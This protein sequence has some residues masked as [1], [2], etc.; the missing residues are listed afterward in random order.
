MDP[1]T[2]QS[3]KRSVPL[4]AKVGWGIAWTAML[5][6]AAMIMRNCATSVIYGLKTDQQAVDSSHQEGL[7]DGGS[8]KEQNLQGHAAE[9]SVLRKAYTTGYREGVDKAR[10]TGKLPE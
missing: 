1:K 5:V 2:R 8:G 6:I 10:Q 3:A 7:R 4:Y 9:N